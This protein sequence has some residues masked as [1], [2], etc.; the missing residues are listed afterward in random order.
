M[1]ILTKNRQEIKKLF[2][3]K[4]N[5]VI[6]LKHNYLTKFTDKSLDFFIFKTLKTKKNNYTLKMNAWIYNRI[7][8]LI[9]WI[10]SCKTKSEFDK[11]RNQI[12]SDLKRLYRLWKD[13]SVSNDENFLY[14]IFD[15]FK[16]M[17]YTIKRQIKKDNKVF[18]IYFT[19]NRKLMNW[20]YLFFLYVNNLIDIPFDK[21]FEK[22]TKIKNFIVH[23]IYIEQ[24]SLKIKLLKIL[25]EIFKSN[26][27]K[28]E[29]Y[30]ITD[31]KSRK[32][33]DLSNTVELFN[34]VIQ[35]GLKKINKNLKFDDKQIIEIKWKKLFFDKE[36]RKTLDEM[37]IFKFFPL[38][39]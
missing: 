22:P 24:N 5:E 35:K 31:I 28:E 10:Y 1:D 39:F 23:D 15:D 21:Y 18:Y 11:Y 16:Y 9:Y 37:Y 26:Y 27:F 7:L 29:Y 12:Q 19:P 2:S 13:N 33:K 32:E 8:K 4:N 30:Y 20:R 36:I 25:E 3:I 38:K 14:N 17:T 6:F 34:D